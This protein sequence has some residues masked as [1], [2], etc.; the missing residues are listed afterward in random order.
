MLIQ[1]VV[2]SILIFI[3]NNGPSQCHQSVYQKQK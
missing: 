3:K 2:I 1:I